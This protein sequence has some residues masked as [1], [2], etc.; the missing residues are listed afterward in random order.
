MVEYLEPLHVRGSR[1]SAYRKTRQSVTDF[2]TL[3]FEAQKS[4][5]HRLQLATVVDES[6][7]KLHGVS[8]LIIDRKRE[9]FVSKSVCK[10]EKTL[11]LGLSVVGKDSGPRG[12]G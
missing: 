10:S 4:P 3:H 12:F 8:H 2:Y 1:N 11:A 7:V 6:T 5:V 9:F